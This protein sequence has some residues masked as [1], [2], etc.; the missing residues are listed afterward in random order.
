M[1]DKKKAKTEKE[2]ETNY[3]EEQTV[4]DSSPTEKEGSQD[5]NQKSG[6]GVDKEAEEVET[7]KEKPKKKLLDK[8][9]K[10]GKKRDEESSELKRVSKKFDTNGDGVISAREAINE[11]DKDV[12]IDELSEDEIVAKTIEKQLE[13]SQDYYV[14][15]VK[16]SIFLLVLGLI[17][18]SLWVI[19]ISSYLKNQLGWS[20]SGMFDSKATQEQN[21]EVTSDKEGV[22]EENVLKVRVKTAIETDSVSK[23]ISLLKSS[24]YD[25]VDLELTNVESE[26]VTVAIKENEG[27]VLS[28]LLTL[29]A[30]DYFAASSSTIL[31]QDS[32]FDAVIFVGE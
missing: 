20:I 29:L 1:A 26:G 10:V 31:T 21:E 15:R 18:M 22:S 6:E 28:N 25:N 7:S 9:S 23:I 12:K 2:L 11:L 16:K 30:D 17:V 24:G 32:D 14:F 8:L 3:P 4:K 19:P 27:M 13:N 5:V